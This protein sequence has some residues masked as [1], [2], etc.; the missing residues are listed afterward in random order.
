MKPINMKTHLE[1]LTV[2]CEIKLVCQELK[3]RKDGRL[4]FMKDLFVVRQ[5]ALSF[6]D[7]HCLCQAFMMLS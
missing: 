1:H 5:S 7:I 3:C 4:N 6:S 2:L